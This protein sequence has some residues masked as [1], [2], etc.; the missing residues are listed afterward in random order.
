LIQFLAIAGLAYFIFRT[1][2]GQRIVDTVNTSIDPQAIQKSMDL[3]QVDFRMKVEGYMADAAA[4]GIP[5]FVTETLRTPERQA[6][7]LGKNDGTTY[8]LHSHHLPHDP[9]G[10]G[11]AADTLPKG[12]VGTPEGNADAVKKLQDP[13]MIALRAKWGL[14]NLPSI[15]D[16][17][18]LEDA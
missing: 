3:L 1:Q 18:H 16:F 12:F 10:K 14:R 5:L 15:N 17:G 4:I 9:D 7:L 11:R 2:F 6:F 8:T 13:R